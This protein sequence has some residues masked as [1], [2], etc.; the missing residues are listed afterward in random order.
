MEDLPGYVDFSAIGIPQEAQ[1]SI[2][3][4]L[5]APLLKLV[6]AATRNDDPEAAALIDK[7]QLIR[8]QGFS[9]AAGER[10]ALE[11]RIAALAGQLEEKK[12]EKVARIRDKED[13][14][15][16]FL[17]VDGEA[18]SGLCLMGF[19]EDGEAVFVNIVGDLDPAQIG[20]I[21]RT[22]DISPLDSLHLDRTTR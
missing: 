12:W 20:R 15:H 5:R 22:F 2:E 4:Y 3:V 11:A 10:P 8:V 21:G 16:V 14:V 7:I 18:V 13:L 19:E 6:A 9:V 17:K 1:T